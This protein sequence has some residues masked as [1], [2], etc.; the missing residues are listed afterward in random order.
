MGSKVDTI[1]HE[2]C[3][4]NYL[5][6]RYLCRFSKV[7]H[8]W[9][10][11]TL[12]PK[13]LGF[14]PQLIQKL[15]VVHFQWRPHSPEDYS[16]PS[17]LA[18]DHRL[19]TC[20]S[21]QRPILSARK[22]FRPRATILVPWNRTSPDRNLNRS[23]N[24]TLYPLLQLPIRISGAI[25]ESAPLKMAWIM[26]FTGYLFYCRLYLFTVSTRLYIHYL[27]INQIRGS[28]VLCVSNRAYKESNLLRDDYL[29]T[30]YIL[31]ITCD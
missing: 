2:G 4:R 24:R 27:E 29:D 5:I 21:L 31:L 13:I 3:R 25:R 10:G 17:S 20:A 28:L 16:A 1:K 30:L 14:K 6:S 22:A 12:Y 23:S 15:F 8:N 26:A 7:P 11:F 18:L 19:I 9:Q